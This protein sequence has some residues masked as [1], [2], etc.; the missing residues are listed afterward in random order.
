MRKVLKSIRFS[1]IALVLIFVYSCSDPIQNYQTGNVI[2]TVPYSNSLNGVSYNDIILGIYPVNVD[3]YKKN[4]LQFKNLNSG[5]VEF[6]S[7]LPDTYAVA[8][9]NLSN[10]YNNRT[11]KFVQVIGGKTTSY[12][13]Y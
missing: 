6:T 12:K 4:A 9:Y 13:L 11:Y 1:L 2:V 8:I 7:L 5:Q 10:G 3:F